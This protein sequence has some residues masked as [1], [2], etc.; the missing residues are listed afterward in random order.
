MYIPDPIERAEA[1]VENWAYDNIKGN[2][3]KCGC[4]KWC[5]LQ[6]GETLSPNPYAIP[7]CPDC[8]EEHYKKKEK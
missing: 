5:D 1:V 2:Q 8:A 6:D 4:G 3:F 7:V